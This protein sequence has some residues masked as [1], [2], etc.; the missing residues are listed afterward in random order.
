MRLREVD[1]SCK[2]LLPS[3]RLLLFLHINLVFLRYRH[4][5]HSFP[6]FLLS[7]SIN[8]LQGC[9]TSFTSHFSLHPLISV[10]PPQTFCLFISI[11]QMSIHPNFPISLSF[12]P[13]LSPIPLSCCYIFASFPLSR[14]SRTSSY[15]IFFCFSSSSHPPV[16]DLP[17]STPSTAY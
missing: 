16:C 4:S 9:Y 1:Y 11:L 3:Q 17:L 15:P 6:P 14:V 13:F 12:P 8:L 7:T 10:S 5:S 2:S